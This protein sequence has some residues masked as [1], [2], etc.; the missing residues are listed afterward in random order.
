MSLPAFC[1]QSELFSTAALSGTLFAQDDRYRLFAKLIYPVLVASR[2]VLEQCYCVEDGRPGIEPVLLLGVSILQ[3]LD[4]MP[5]RQ[6]IEMLRYHAGWNFALNRQIG[7]GVFH[8]TTLVNFRNRLNE[9][10]QSALGFTAILKALEKAGPL[11]TAGVGAGG[12]PSGSA[13]LLGGAL[14]TLR[15]KP[16]RLPCRHRDPGPQDVGSRRRRLATLAVAAQP[17]AVRIKFQTTGTL[18]G[19]CIPGAI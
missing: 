17:G 2:W 5:D 16:G 9:H 10:Q 12:E 15:R 1:T 7:D 18:V 19:P 4:G 11:G 13:T 8:P 3:E 6:A 14:G